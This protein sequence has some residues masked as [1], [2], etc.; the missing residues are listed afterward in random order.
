MNKIIC[1]NSKEM[2]ELTEKALDCVKAVLPRTVT[3]EELVG[4]DIDIYRALIELG[5]VKR[6]LSGFERFGDLMSK[7]DER[8][9]KGQLSNVRFALD[10][11]NGDL[12]ED[13]G[14]ALEAIDEVIRLTEQGKELIWSV[15]EEFTDKI[16]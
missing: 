1:E 9:L 14:D 16:E 13:V 15:P 8:I 10:Y 7:Q 12:G 3:V 2:L 6:C 11:C 5:K 4:N